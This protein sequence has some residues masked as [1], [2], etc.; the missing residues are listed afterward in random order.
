MFYR[1]SPSMWL[2]AV[3]CCPALPQACSVSGQL[4]H[5]SLLKFTGLTSPGRW[6]PIHGHKG[7]E[8]PGLGFLQKLAAS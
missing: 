6:L 7:L 3:L 1:M 4:R 5:A 2:T 8:E